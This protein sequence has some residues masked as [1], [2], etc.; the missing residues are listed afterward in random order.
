MFFLQARLELKEAPG[1]MWGL[2]VLLVRSPVAMIQ[3]LPET[4]EG[5][6]GLFS[7]QFEVTVQH[8]SG[9]QS[10]PHYICSQET[11]AECQLYLHLLIQTGLPPQRAGLPTSVVLIKI[12]PG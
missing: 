7:S 2:W 3:C 6:K 8:V 5:R 12:T 1:G 10:R 9:S 4:T 11:S